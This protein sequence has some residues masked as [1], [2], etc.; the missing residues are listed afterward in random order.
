MS[1]H[2]GGDGYGAAVDAVSK[3][4]SYSFDVGLGHAALVEILR[5]LA[6][7]LENGDL[8]RDPYG[9]LDSRLVDARATA[10]VSAE[11]NFGQLRVHLVVGE[12]GELDTH[13]KWVHSAHASIADAKAV[14]EQLNRMAEAIRE[15]GAAGPREAVQ[16]LIKADHRH[17]AAGLLMEEPVRFAGAY[18]FEPGTFYT[19]DTRQLQFGRQHDEEAPEAPP[20][21]ALTPE[22]L[23]LGQDLPP[24]WHALYRELLG[25]LPAGTRLDYAVEK[26]GQM[27]AWSY[28]APPGASNI[29]LEYRTRSSSVCAQCGEPGAMT[30]S[31]GHCMAYCPE[32]ARRFG[33]HPPA[34]RGRS[35]DD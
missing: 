10:D 16:R 22:N 32:H 19:L 14:A 30:V 29:C 11:A 23:A 12:A 4:I 2:V 15:V 25:A 5:D 7:D 31:R 26:L 13:A 28:R 3:A 9:P 8:A 24:G 20:P 27:V 17:P 18:L 1:T 33:Y 6:N 21:N 35:T 34:P